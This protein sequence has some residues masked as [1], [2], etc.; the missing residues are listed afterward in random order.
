M[1]QNAKYNSFSCLADILAAILKLATYIF[2][3]ILML[4]NYL[5]LKTFYQTPKILFCV[6]WKAQYD[7]DNFSTSIGDHNRENRELEMFS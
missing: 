2:N 7:F 5:V 4:M 3:R 1:T 6:V